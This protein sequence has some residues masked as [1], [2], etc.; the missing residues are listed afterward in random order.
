MPRVLITG[1]AGLVGPLFATRLL[2]DPSYTVILTDINTPPIPPKAKFPENCHP[3]QTDL[4]DPAS[5]SK[6]ISES[7]PLD[8]V[9]IF[10]GI[11]S[12]GSEANFE[13]GMKVNLHSTAA[14]LEA[15]RLANKEGSK[16]IRVV[17]SS[18]QAV[19][20]NPLPKVIDESVLPTPEG[21]YGAQKLI[22]ET[23]LNDYTRKGYLDGYSL[24]FPTITIRGGAPTQAASSFIS[25]IIREPM[26]GEVCVIPIQDRG[27][28]SWICSPK[29]LVENLWHA[30]HLGSDA[31]PKHKRVV[32]L[33]G[34]GVTV[35]EMMDVLAKV[36][37]E[38]KLKLLK[39]ESDPDMERILRSWG[40]EFDNTL[41]F[42]LGFKKD[43]GFERVVRDYVDGL[44]D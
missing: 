25:G 41:G 27:F 16:P 22:I 20:G 3:V 42:S 40:T 19:Y 30:L 33:P 12:S 15:L 21:S 11:M 14:L 17:Y 35:Q 26:N 24:R 1:G 18:S 36:G 28:V 8:A 7:L 13:L 34:F 9:C 10:H 5:L 32:N 37:G 29:V 43:E 44:K 31:L 6:L 23:L 4:C 39:E 2:S 38:E